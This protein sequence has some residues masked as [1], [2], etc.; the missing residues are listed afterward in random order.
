M[1]KKITYQ[2][3]VDLY[4]DSNINRMNKVVADDMNEIKDVVNDNFQ[5]ASNN[6]GLETDTWISSAIYSIGDIAVYNENTY[7]NLTGT[8]TATP[9][10]QDSTNWKVMPLIVDVYNTST[11]NAYS[12][13]ETNN[14]IKDEYSLYETK[15]HKV[16]IDN[17][18]IYRKVIETT[19][20]TNVTEIRYTLS[21][22]GLGN[23]SSVIRSYS[24][25]QGNPMEEDY[26]SASNDQLRT[27][28]NPDLDT[29]IILVGSTYPVR[30]CTIY[31]IIEYT[32]TTDNATRTIN[33]NYTK[34][35]NGDDG[36]TKKEE[37]R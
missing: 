17:K 19:M 1:A 24:V 6:F 11:K 21:T 23:I 18:P 4:E 7:K 9:P 12:C 2:D 33:T 32:K 22:I 13:N 10:D 31:T 29:L 37:S 25:S 16:W 15:T 27:I 20:P 36:E 3:K 34:K 28:I 30:P 35:S 5:I 8:N 14:L 26:F